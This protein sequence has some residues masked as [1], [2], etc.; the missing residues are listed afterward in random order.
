M[1]YCELASQTSVRELIYTAGKQKKNYKKRHT[2]NKTT[3]PDIKPH[4]RNLHF[5]PERFI[6]H[7]DEPGRLPEL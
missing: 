1:P 2:L 3:Q 5:H 7:S 6:N 4:V